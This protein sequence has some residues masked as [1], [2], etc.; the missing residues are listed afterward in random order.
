MKKLNITEAEFKKAL[1]IKKVCTIWE[2]VFLFFT[3]RNMKEIAKY[4]KRGK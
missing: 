1:F 2:T 3:S 4:E